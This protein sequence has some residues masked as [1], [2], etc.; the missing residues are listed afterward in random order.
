MA[1]TNQPKGRANRGAK[2]S[3][4]R[5]PQRMRAACLGLGAASLLVS[6]LEPADEIFEK[7]GE[8]GRI[9]FVR[10]P[11][12]GTNQL[13]LTPMA[14]NSDEFYPGTDLHSLSPIGPT[15]KLVNLTARYTRTSAN[16]NSWGAALDPEVSYDGKRILFSMRKPSDNSNRNPRW[17]LYE[18]DVDGENLVQLTDASGGDDM[19]PAYLPDGRIV[20]T[21]T[22]SQMRDEYERRQV[23]NL[24]IGERDGNGLLKNIRQLS[25]NQSHDFNPWVHSSGKIFFSRWDHLGPPNKIPLFSINPD[26]TKQFVLYGADETFSGQGNTSGARAFLEAR[27]LGEGGIVTSLMERPSRFE[28]GAIAVIDLG[29][30]PITAAPEVVTP[31]SSP[32]NTTQKTSDAIY[33]SPYPIKDGSK[34][35]IL[36]AMSPHETGGDMGGDAF[37]NYD[38]YVMDKN[39]ENRRLIFANAETNDYDPIVVEERPIPNS[40]AA[41]SN[42]STDKWV[43]EGLRTGANTG[44]FFDADVYSRMDNDGQGKPDPKWAN[45]GETTDNA[46]GQAKYVRFLEA[47]PMPSN[48]DMRGGETGD[49]DFEKQRVIGYGPIQRDGSFA[50]EVPANK[51]LHLQVLDEDGVMLVNQLQWIHVM[52]GERRVCT[53]CHGI[54]EKDKDITQFTIHDDGKVTAEL[55]TTREFMASFATV[56]KVLEHSAAKTDTVDFFDPRLIQRAADSVSAV[57]NNREWNPGPAYAA[58]T[59]T[60]QGLLDNRCVSCHGAGTASAQ[61]GGL[62]LEEIK[63]DSTWGLERISTVY[64]RL[65]N[66]N[67]YRDS[68]GERRNYVNSRGARQSPFAWVLY[69]RHLVFRKSDASLM[70]S[71]SYDHTALWEKDSTGFI[72]V[73]APENKDLLTLVE[74]MD[75]GAQFTNS[76]G[77]Y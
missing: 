19:D 54:R 59:N 4:S 16:P 1:H 24:Y 56:A 75:M 21:S 76:V 29:G 58:R 18:M 10:E 72:N 57:R 9:V 20:F 67:G 44:I 55:E 74:W 13:R 47:V 60:I 64:N 49:T 45:H 66:S 48:Y 26:G 70:R 38:L 3:G 8:A 2:G 35:R 61:G 39:G 51:S 53:G 30:K 40:E 50:L 65:L 22:R 31:N 46:T 33:K 15:G 5:K 12:V 36:V 52:P 69:N 34:E 42:L 73:F 71:M 7:S 28:G 41:L 68:K 11:N 37:V 25:F 43:A 23:S 77:K 17:H 14:N 32:Y 6:C 27:E 62:V 63:H